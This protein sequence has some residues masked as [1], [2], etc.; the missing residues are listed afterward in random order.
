[1]DEGGA[2]RPAKAHV[3]V[4]EKSDQAIMVAPV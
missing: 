4:F 3:W 1:M 2:D